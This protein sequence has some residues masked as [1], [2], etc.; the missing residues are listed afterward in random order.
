MILVVL[1]ILLA[2]AAPARVDLLTPQGERQGHVTVDPG[3][4]RIDLYDH[5]SRR[6]GYGTIRGDRID[7]YDTRGRRIGSGTMRPVPAPPPRGTR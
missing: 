5:L 6:T 2:P 7:L 4:A 1:T 3:N